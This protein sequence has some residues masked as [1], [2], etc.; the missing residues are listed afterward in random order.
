MKHK[1][2]TFIEYY[3]RLNSTKTQI[4]F[5]IFSKIQAYS[6]YQPHKKI[7]GEKNII[8]SYDFICPRNNNKY[9]KRI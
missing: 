1:W 9:L 6:L 4:F 3:L 7:L 8:D 5:E 2:G